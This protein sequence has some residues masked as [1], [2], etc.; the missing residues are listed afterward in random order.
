MTNEAVALISLIGIIM[1]V[2]TV[3]CAFLCHYLGQYEVR[4]EAVE[5]GVAE[6]YLDE[7]NVKQFRWKGVK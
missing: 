3:A 7:D 2:G 1:L 6:Y 4:E 5:N